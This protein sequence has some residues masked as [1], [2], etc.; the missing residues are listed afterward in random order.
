MKFSLPKL[1][2]SEI[3][4]SLFDKV[5]ESDLAQQIKDT[6]IAEIKEEIQ[7]LIS[8]YLK[9]NQKVLIET[10]TEHLLHL[11]HDILLARINGE[12]E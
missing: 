4:D 7:P 9:E 8:E 3:I 6:V 10:A 12:S 11:V 1:D 5:A 2:T